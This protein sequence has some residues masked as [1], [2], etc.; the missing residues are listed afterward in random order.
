ML[1]DTFEWATRVIGVA[2]ECADSE[3]MQP[4]TQRYIL[5]IDFT[6]CIHIRK[7]S[8]PLWLL[9]RHVLNI[10]LISSLQGGLRLVNSGVYISTGFV[11]TPGGACSRVSQLHQKR[12]ANEIISFKRH[13]VR[14]AVAM[15]NNDLGRNMIG[16]ALSCLFSSKTMQILELLE[17]YPCRLK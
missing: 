7:A 2:L 9:P 1:D 3:N 17:S 8:H 10:R 6:I 12:T 5:H 13:P 14:K 16:A 4:G 15:K 11:N